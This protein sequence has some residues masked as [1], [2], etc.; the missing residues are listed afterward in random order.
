MSDHRTP[1][2]A[3][4]P[5]VTTAR[6]RE[7]LQSVTQMTVL[8]VRWTLQGTDRAAYDA[9]H[10]PG[11]WFVDLD[12]DLADP[13]GPGGR[14]PLPGADRFAATMRACGVSRHVPVVLLDQRDGTSAARLWWLLRRHGHPDV[15]LLD[16]GFDRWAAQG[17]PVS[18]DPTPL[19]PGDFVAAG[20]HAG[21]LDADAAAALA[22]AGVLLDARSLARY[23]GTEELV[24]PVA[25]HVPGAVSAPT[26]DNTG[27][28]GRLLAPELLRERFSRLGVRDDLPVGTYCGS[29]V[30]AAHQ[31]LALEV[32][33]FEAALYAGSWS[34]WITD[35]TRPVALGSEPAARA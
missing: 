23:T 32:A 35:P 12:A 21:V 30:N 8:D 33:G 34:D 26:L 3:A 10:V 1:S 4:N 19:M 29:G 2:R 7:L 25:G 16:G 27:P 20:R 6:L 11:S 14:H 22:A 28:D 15:R 18:T 5:L 24:D 17:G 13:P 9:G 31:V